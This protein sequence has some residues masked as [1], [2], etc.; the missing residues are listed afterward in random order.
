MCN[1][2]RT[3]ACH[4]C[5]PLWHTWGEGSWPL[6]VS[7]LGLSRDGGHTGREQSSPPPCILGEEVVLPPKDRRPCRHPPARG[8]LSYGGWLY[9]TKVHP[10]QDPLRPQGLN[11]SSAPG[12]H[13]RLW[14]TQASC[15]CC[16]VMATCTAQFRTRSL[17]KRH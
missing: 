13:G 10:I 14:G 7:G 12:S 8:T 17:E 16:S 6:G 11:P 1:V 9:P 5:V 3:K 2:L 4:V 15:P